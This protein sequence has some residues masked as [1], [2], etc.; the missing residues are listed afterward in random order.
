VE[1]G[2]APSA[3][4]EFVVFRVGRTQDELQVAEVGN[5]IGAASLRGA[6]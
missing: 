5:R 2:A 3:P 1:V 4:A 6:A